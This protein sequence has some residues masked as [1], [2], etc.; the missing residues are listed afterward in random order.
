MQSSYD[1]YDVLFSSAFHQIYLNI[2]FTD[3]TFYCNS[4]SYPNYPMTQF[5][6][7]F[8][9]FSCCLYWPQGNKWS[10]DNQ[11]SLHAA[12]LLYHHSYILIVCIAGDVYFLGFFFNVIT[13]YVL[14][15]FKWLRSNCLFSSFFL[16]Y[17]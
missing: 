11:R 17:A 10:T 4:L 5:L 8:S 6:L 3:N 16:C 2:V 9:V 15:H 1:K 13:L 12:M 7:G 14:C